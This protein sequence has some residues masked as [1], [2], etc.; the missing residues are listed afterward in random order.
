MLEFI[1]SERRKEFLNESLRWYDI[2]RH[3]IE[4]THVDVNGDTYVLEAEDLKKAIQIPQ[5]A[6]VNGIE[7]N[8]R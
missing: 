7:A 6:T 2:K 1:L 3:N 5:K 8:P 4:V